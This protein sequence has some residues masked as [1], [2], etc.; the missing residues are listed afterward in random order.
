[1]DQQFRKNLK[2]DELSFE[3]G[4]ILY[5]VDDQSNKDWWKARCG[6]KCGLIPANYGTRLLI[7]VVVIIF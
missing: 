5:L 7:I 2:E 3:E 1:M 6:L 4:D